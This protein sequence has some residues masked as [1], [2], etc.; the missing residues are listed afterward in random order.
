RLR[1]LRRGIGRVGERR[2]MRALI[3][4]ALLRRLGVVIRVDAG[5]AVRGPSLFRVDGFC[6]LARLGLVRMLRL[7]MLRLWVLRLRW[8]W[9]MR[10][11]GSRSV[12]GRLRS[13]SHAD[14]LL[15]RK[16]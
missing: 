5:R 4:A 13:R 15:M 9:T 16:T 6:V 12:R 14:V 7:R 2:G 3:A 10:L 11:T 1:G 8:R